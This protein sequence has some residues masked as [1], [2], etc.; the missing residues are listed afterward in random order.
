VH[1]AVSVE[2]LSAIAT[3]LRILEPVPAALPVTDAMQWLFTAL[4][5]RRGWCWRHMCGG[6]RVG[7]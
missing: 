5:G 6:V 1:W 7:C 3:A 2:E 4:E